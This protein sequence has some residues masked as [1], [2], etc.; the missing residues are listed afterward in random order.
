MLEEIKLISRKSVKG[1][2]QKLIDILE[3]KLG[4]WMKYP[5]N[6]QMIDSRRDF[7]KFCDGNIEL[8]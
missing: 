2:E 3:Q 4:V 1:R 6:R 5:E 7:Q 8:A